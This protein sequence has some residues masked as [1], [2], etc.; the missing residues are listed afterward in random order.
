MS[1]C[2]RMKT[3]PHV[4][5][6][7]ILPL[8]P[9]Y[10]HIHTFMTELHSCWQRYPSSS[11]M[12]IM[13]LL[14]K[15]ISWAKTATEDS[16]LVRMHLHSTHHCTPHTT[17]LSTPS[18][19]WNTTHQI[20]H[21]QTTYMNNTMYAHYTNEMISFH[22]T[23]LTHN[24]G[25]ITI[26]AITVLHALSLSSLWQAHY[27]GGW[28]LHQR[29]RSIGKHPTTI[30]HWG[31]Q[32]MH[33]CQLSY[34]SL[35]PIHTYVRTGILW[36]EKLHSSPDFHEKHWGGRVGDDMDGEVCGCGGSLWLRGGKR[37]Q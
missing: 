30:L 13:H 34:T 33:V 11:V 10:I 4:W 6:L 20:Q 8:Y 36:T 17:A 21:T 7:A 19:T 28:Q 24:T 3:I 29:I 25:K 1:K 37:C 5:L 14:R 32:L 16:A 15:K 27:Q 23:Q 26:T 22:R 35:L 31:E 12:L 18:T 2:V 9:V